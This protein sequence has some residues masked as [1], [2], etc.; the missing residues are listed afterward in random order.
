[1]FWRLGPTYSHMCCR[2]RSLGN[3]TS[4]VLG[5]TFYTNKHQHVPKRCY[6]LKEH[7]DPQEGL[8]DH[9]RKSTGQQKAPTNK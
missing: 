4:L 8:H 9:L 2:P 3:L 7:E 5:H 6:Y 1:M